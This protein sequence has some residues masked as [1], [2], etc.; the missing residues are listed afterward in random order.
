MPRGKTKP[1]FIR[2]MLCKTVEELP[3]GNEWVYEVK[4]GGQ[5][6]IVVKEGSQVRVFAENGNRLDYPE[7]EET[8]REVSQQSAVIDGEIIGLTRDGQRCEPR[9]DCHLKLYAFDLMHING[10]DL[11]GEPIERRKSKLCT[12]TIDSD[13]LFNPSLE[14]EPEQLVEEV[15]RLSLQGVVAK[16]KGSPYEAGKCSGAW[17][18][19]RVRKLTG[20]KRVKD[21]RSLVLR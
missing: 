6:T 18:N 7:I 3:R 21:R 4:W 17:A 15:R 19:L 1:G 5:R 20:R 14:C 16:R 8:V 10:R 11:T 12:A 9:P 2:P 13:L